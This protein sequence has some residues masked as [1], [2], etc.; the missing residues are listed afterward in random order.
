MS[1]DV[2]RRHLEVMIGIIVSCI[3]CL[4]ALSERLL[5]KIGMHITCM[6]ST[7]KQSTG[8][9]AY[10]LKNYESC[11][12]TTSTSQK[13]FG[14]IENT[15]QDGSQGSKRFNAVVSPEEHYSPTI[16]KKSVIVKGEAIS[17]ESASAKT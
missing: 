12:S 15:V 6:N 2:Y 4:K 14:S 17:W 11:Q 3:P 5:K 9:A 1:A 16:D 13:P 8:P 10:S 7:V